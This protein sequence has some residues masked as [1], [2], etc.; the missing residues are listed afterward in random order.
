MANN[1]PIDKLDINSAGSERVVNALKREGVTDARSL[2]RRTEKQLLAIHNIGSNDI[3]RIKRA[4][5][6]HGY[7]L[8]KN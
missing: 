8:A 2:A 1:V 5:R 4:L 6:A 7:R 3:P